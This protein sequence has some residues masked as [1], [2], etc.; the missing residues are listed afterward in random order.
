MSGKANQMEDSEAPPDA[1]IPH[2]LEP[3]K[4]EGL[5]I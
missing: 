2:G 3:D 4:L 1:M 5:N